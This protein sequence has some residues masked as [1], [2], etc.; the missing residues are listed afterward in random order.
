[1]E[2]ARQFFIKSGTTIGTYTNLFLA[3]QSMVKR[4]SVFLETGTIKD[5][6]RGL[7]KMYA[8]LGGDMNASLYQITPG[9]VFAHVLDTRMRNERHEDIFSSYGFK[10]TILCLL[11]T[12]DAADE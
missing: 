5:L 2:Q 9:Y 1:M 8:G 4:Y 12:S 3:V 7:I 6:T 10:Q 11:Y